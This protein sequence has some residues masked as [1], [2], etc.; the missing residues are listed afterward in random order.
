VKRLWLKWAG[1]VSRIYTVSAL[2]PA[3]GIFLYA[4]AM[5]SISYPL[6]L[7]SVPDTVTVQGTVKE[8]GYISAINWSVA[9]LL[10]VPL[11]V[12]FLFE[13]FA[14]VPDSIRTLASRGMLVDSELNSVDR[15]LPLQDWNEA[16]RRSVTVTAVLFLIAILEPILEW[17][18]SSGFPLFT[19]RLKD[20]AENE[21]DWSVGALLR[22]ADGLHRFLN[23]VFSFMVFGQQTVMIAAFSLILVFTG[24]FCFFFGR[25]RDSWQIVPDPGDRDKHKGFEIFETTIT[26]LLSAALLS[27]T[28]FYSSILQNYYLRTTFASLFQFCDDDILAGSAALRSRAPD[29]PSLLGRVP[30]KLVG[31]PINFSVGE[32]KLGSLIVV[33]LILCV[34]LWI[35]RGVA[36][37]GAIAANYTGKI[38]FW[39]LSYISLNT[40]L[41]VCALAGLSLIFYRVGL[42]IFGLLFCAL[43]TRCAISIYRKIVAGKR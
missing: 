40:Y 37:R 41:F 5:C 36:K 21:L 35:L 23:A 22:G 38:E 18:A 29:I 42:W 26:H 4:A 27:L 3:A 24:T 34:P 30:T 28:V 11:I 20:V 19:G 25:Q 43:L 1:L 13:A 12:Y 31:N 7:A 8:V 33:L 9:Y 32:T 17:W 14:S 39:P 6:G 2:A 16:L 15:A 10:P